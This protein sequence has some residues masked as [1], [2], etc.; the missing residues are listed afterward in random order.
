MAIELVSDTTESPGRAGVAAR[1]ELERELEGLHTQSFGWA[2]SC[3]GWRR[4]EAEE[5]LQTAYLRVLDGHARFGGRSS[6]KTWFFGVV[7]RVAGERRRSFAIR[8]AALLRFRARE[9]EPDPTPDPEGLSERARAHARLCACLRK[10]SRR[11][12]DVLHLVF[13]QEMTV[14]D[15]AAVMGIP[16]G[17]A[18]THYGRGKAQLRKLLD[19]SPAEGDAR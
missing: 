14:E 11:Q 19:A 16:V 17:T 9:P 5:V 1:S 10:L 3:C 4:A 2:M 13:Y 12:R 6:L 15:A 7:R 8:N 18:R